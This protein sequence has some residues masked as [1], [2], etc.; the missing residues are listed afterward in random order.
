LEKNNVKLT[1]IGSAA[2]LDEFLSM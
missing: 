2:L 1:Y